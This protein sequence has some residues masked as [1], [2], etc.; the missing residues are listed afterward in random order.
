MVDFY[1]RQLAVQHLA[2]E[3]RRGQHGLIQKVSNPPKDCAIEDTANLDAKAKPPPY[4]SKNVGSY[5]DLAREIDALKAE[6]AE[7]RGMLT[8]IATTT[9][10]M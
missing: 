5:D 10:D 2:A 6:V 9:A 3:H 8:S 4:A 7:L 1:N